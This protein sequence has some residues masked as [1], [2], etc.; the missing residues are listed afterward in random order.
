M[1]LEDYFDFL[2]PD[3]IRLKGHR[4]GIDTILFDYLDGLTPEEIVLRYPTLTF[5]EVY[6]TI[7]YYWHNQAQVDAYLQAVDEYGERMR[8]QQEK[9]PPPGVKRLRKLARAR[10]KA[11]TSE[12]YSSSAR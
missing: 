9:N 3:D 2:A 10:Q 8:R 4:I 5:E 6:A 1:R 11:L 12:H 7:T